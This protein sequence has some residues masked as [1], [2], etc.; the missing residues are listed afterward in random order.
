MFRIIVAS[1]LWDQQWVLEGCEAALSRNQMPIY[2]MFMEKDYKA[3]KDLWKS[4]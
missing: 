2:I 4:N 3:N 1:D